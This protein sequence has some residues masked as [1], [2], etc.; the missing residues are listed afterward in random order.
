MRISKNNQGFGL[1]EVVIGLAI[2]LVAL[3]AL[4]GTFSIAI[5]STLSNVEK[6]QATYL[7]EEGVEAVK[8]LRDE[9]WT[10]KIANLSVGTSY[11]LGWDSGTGKWSTTTPQYFGNFWRVFQ[12]DNVYRDVN[13]D[14][15]PSGTLDSDI[16]KLTVAVSWLNRGA[17][18]TKSVTTYIT[19]LFGN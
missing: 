19:N 4:V 12:V 3:L 11:S 5:K 7:M 15:A 17:T 2:I 14:V 18:T 16:K 10:D 8:L 9:S 1:L 13:N 6:I